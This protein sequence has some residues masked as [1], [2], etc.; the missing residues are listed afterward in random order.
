MPNN[1]I[2]DGSNGPLY[3]AA[4]NSYT[5][6]GSEI[7]AHSGTSVQAGGA[8]AINAS[9]SLSLGVLG[10]SVN[11]SVRI[12]NPSGSG[13]TVYLGQIIGYTSISLS[14]LSSFSAQ[15]TVYSGGTVAS[16][17][18]VTPVNLNL[19]SGTASVASVTT[20][21]NAVT[22]GTAFILYP[23]Q[24]GPFSFSV[25]GGVAVPPGQTLTINVVGTLTVLGLLGVGAEVIWW[26]V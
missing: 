6:P 25:G 8:F 1:P 4:A 7:P 19:G 10:G 21:I 15:V 14:L 9:N 22:G 20:S 11:S 24:P 13:K 26:E 18:T 16:P 12:A 2:F 23:L 5:Q 3:G 17:T